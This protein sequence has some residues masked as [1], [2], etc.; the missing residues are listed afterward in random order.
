MDSL[1]QVWGWFKQGF[2]DENP[3]IKLFDIFGFL[4]KGSVHAFGELIAVGLECFL[5]FL[6]VGIYVWVFVECIGFV[7]GLLI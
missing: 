5:L 2:N 1:K 4:D 3:P 7:I 6:N